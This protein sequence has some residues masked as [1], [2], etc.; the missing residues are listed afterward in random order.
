MRGATSPPANVRGKRVAVAFF[1]VGT[2]LL[3]L[4]AVA[5][6]VPLAGLRS[7]FAAY[8][9]GGVAAGVVV[10]IGMPVLS[11]RAMAR[12]NL[13]RWAILLFVG[14]LGA[15]VVGT[16]LLTFT[17]VVTAVQQ[18]HSAPSPGTFLVPASMAFTA[19]GLTLGALSCP[20]GVA[21]LVSPG[22]FQRAGLRWW[23]R[24]RRRRPATVGY[25]GRAARVPRTIP[26]RLQPPGHGTNQPWLRGNLH[27][28]P[29]R[30]EWVPSTSAG[31]ALPV[32]LT[33][34]TLIPGHHA[35][36]RRS[37]GTR[38]KIIAVRTDAGEI[39]L[40]MGPQLFQLAQLAAAHS[41]SP[42]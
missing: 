27:V 34:A 14:Y 5:I 22:F 31:G 26:V 24:Q 25:P 6:I 3:A 13:P 35:A 32:E 30:L 33:D 8:W 21:A 39:R 12:D 40:T 17:N 19:T 16:R 9:Y 20:F 23:A 11:L 29:G 18:P 28:T 1:V 7:H 37:S 38:S 10:A 15:V 4:L 36:R 41:D 2:P 42:R